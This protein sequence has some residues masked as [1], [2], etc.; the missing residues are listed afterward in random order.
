[1]S[2]GADIDFSTVEKYLASLPD[3]VDSYPDCRATGATFRNLLSAVS[4]PLDAGLPA[5]LEKWIRA[6]PSENEWVPVV[7]LCAFHSAVFDFM[8]AQKGGMD[9]YVEWTYERNKS[10]LS[11]PAYAPVLA[12]GSPELLLTAYRARWS[13]FYRGCML[14]VM[15][16]TK[17]SMS[18]RLSYPAYCWPEVSRHSLVAAFRAGITLMNAKGLLVSS[19]EISPRVSQYDLRWS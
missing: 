19:S 8:F 17:T 9:A 5:V 13:V 12:A 2:S 14:D 15:G 1:M 6:H 16:A 11:A 3:G 10:M 4:L 7:H 18:L